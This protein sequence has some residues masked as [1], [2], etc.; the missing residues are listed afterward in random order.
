M[1]LTDDNF[2][3]IVNAV[4]EGRGIYDNI[5]KFL[6]YLLACNAGEVLL[7]FVAALVG[8]PAPLTAI[9]LL[10]IN[11]VTDGLPA[12]ALGMEPPQERD[13]MRRRPRP[14]HEPVITKRAHKDCSCSITASSWQRL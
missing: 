7:M 6:H 10:W 4:E 14:P 11:L 13:I 9:Q 8:W 12:L 3:S 2:A 5:Q 1:V